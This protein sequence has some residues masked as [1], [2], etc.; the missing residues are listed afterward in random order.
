MAR[1]QHRRGLSPRTRGR[2]PARHV[3]RRRRGSIPA[4]AGETRPNREAGIAPW[5]YPRERG[6]DQG[7]APR[8]RCESGLSPRTRGRLGDR[9]RRFRRLGS[10]PANAGETAPAAWIKGCGGVYPRERGGDAAVCPSPWG[11]SGLSP[12]TR[13][14]PDQIDPAPLAVGSIPAN[15]GETGKGSRLRIASRVYPRERGGDA[16]G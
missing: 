3:E 8:P 14:R 15:A 16:R 12:R 1:W 2:R 11:S 5:V 10:I 9:G 6:G 4:N 13:G 7:C